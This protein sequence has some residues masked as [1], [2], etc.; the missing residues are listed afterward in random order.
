MEICGK[1]NMEMNR[2]PFSVRTSSNDA[3]SSQLSM[4]LYLRFMKCVILKG[5][6]NPNQKKTWNKIGYRELKTLQSRVVH[7][8]HAKNVTS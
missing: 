3:C 2:S 1:R 6:R 7:R 5:K 4:S 8:S